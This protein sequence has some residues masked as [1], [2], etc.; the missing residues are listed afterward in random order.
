MVVLIKHRDKLL[1]FVFVY[2]SVVFYK[3]PF[4]VSP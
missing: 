2:T 4:P 1:P 3:E